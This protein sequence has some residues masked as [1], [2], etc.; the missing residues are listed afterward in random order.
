MRRVGPKLKP[1]PKCLETATYPVGMLRSPGGCPWPSGRNL[2]HSFKSVI[3]P[4]P[5]YC[6]ALSDEHADNHGNSSQRAGIEKF[7]RRWVP[8]FLFPLKKCSYLSIA[9]DAT[10]SA[11]VGREPFW[12]NRNRWQVMVSIFLFLSVLKNVCTIADRC[13]SKDA[14]GRPNEENSNNDFLH[15]TQTSCA[16]HLTKRMQIRSNVFC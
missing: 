5:E 14:T 11:R 3:L 9:R 6:A 4:V 10:N 13:H 15:R 1:G 2:R 16:R 12:R 7:S 8:H